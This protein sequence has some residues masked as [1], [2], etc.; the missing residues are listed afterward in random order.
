PRYT[1][2]EVSE[3]TGL[4]PELLRRFWRALGFL[5]PADEERALTDLDVEAA[6]ILRTM[7]R[8]GVTEVETAV[9][10][11]RV[12]G[13]S[14]A[15]IAEAGVVRAATT[16]GAE[17]DSVMAADAFS[18]IAG[19]L[20]PAMDRLLG[21]VWRRHV[22]A[23]ARRT[24]LLRTE[25]RQWGARQVLAVG[26][27]DM[28]G[29]TVLSQHLSDHEL[30]TVVQR[31]EEISYDIVTGLGGRMVKTIGD[32]AMFV[33]EDAVDAASIGLSLAEAYADDDLL[34]DVRVGLSA[35]QVLVNDGDYFGPTVNL[36]ARIVSIARPGTVLVSDDFHRQVSDRAGELSWRRLGIRQLKD[37]GPVTLW[38][39]GRAGQEPAGIGG[40]ADDRRRL[41]WDRLVGVVRDLD[42]LRGAGERFLSGGRRGGRT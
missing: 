11:A 20:L 37:L 3:A 33:A 23:V 30:A 28:V 16:L 21:Y 35:G 14:M 9:Q 12:I 39:C 4:A 1:T 34:S 31:F 17:E 42:E 40:P 24:M 18:G 41:R 6:G 13:S 15:R 5:E 38:W 36:A 32:E 10:L 26:F 29:F 7:V 2:V 22:Q 8:L 19:E 25:G 27:A